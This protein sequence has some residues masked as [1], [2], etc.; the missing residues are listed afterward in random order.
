MI[1]VAVA[2]A[3]H[4][5]ELCG[6]GSIKLR[7]AYPTSTASYAMAWIAKEEQII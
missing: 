4:G 7:V 6:G 5:A 2:R 1:E 3:F